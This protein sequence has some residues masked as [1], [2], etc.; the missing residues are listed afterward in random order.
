MASPNPSELFSIYAARDNPSVASPTRRASFFPHAPRRSF[1]TGERESD[2]EGKRERAKPAEAIGFCC[3]AVT[4]GQIAARG[5]VV[6]AT[7]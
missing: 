2:R 5:A 7:L 6:H 4:C 1:E 3:A